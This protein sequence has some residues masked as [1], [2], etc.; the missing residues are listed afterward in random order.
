MLNSI[1]GCPATI[2]CFRRDLGVT[3]ACDPCEVAREGFFESKR[4][5]IESRKQL[6]IACPLRSVFIFRQRALIFVYT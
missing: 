4:Q 3:S 2:L 6:N 1:D 5:Y